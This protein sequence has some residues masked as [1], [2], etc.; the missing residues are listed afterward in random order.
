MKQTSSSAEDTP[1]FFA[2]WI[3]DQFL[4]FTPRFVRPSAEMFRT[5]AVSTAVPCSD[6]VTYPH[7]FS[8]VGRPAFLPCFG[9]VERLRELLRHAQHLPQ[10]EKPPHQDGKIIK[11]FQ[12]TSWLITIS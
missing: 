1:A 3:T 8:D 11:L 9:I 7:A 6:V 12:K 2:A 4:R 10:I 5:I